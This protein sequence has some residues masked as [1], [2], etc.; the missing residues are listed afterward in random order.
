[1]LQQ[2]HASVSLLSA[3][4]RVYRLS[5][6]YLSADRLLLSLRSCHVTLTLG[7]CLELRKVLGVVLKFLLDLGMI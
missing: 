5:T 3:C 2:R 6:G 7:C 1:M 4:K